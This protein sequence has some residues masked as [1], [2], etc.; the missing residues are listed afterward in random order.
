MNGKAIGIGV[1]VVSV[2]GYFGWKAYET[3]KINKIIEVLNSF[4]IFGEGEIPSFEKVSTNNVK[5]LIV[6]V[7]ACRSNFK[8]AKDDL[9]ASRA[10]EVGTKL[11]TTLAN[12][13]EQ[14][15]DYN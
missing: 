14:V 12:R 2:I 5:H 7:D 3:I 8:M 9:S 6:F 1:A 10:L 13:G 15:P 11:R 4:I